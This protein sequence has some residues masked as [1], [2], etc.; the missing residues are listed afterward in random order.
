MV[1][2]GRDW[3][4]TPIPAG[5]MK[6][7]IILIGVMLL[8][9]IELHRHAN[10]HG[11]KRCRADPQ[12]EIE[13][14]FNVEINETDRLNQIDQSMNTQMPVEV[15]EENKEVRSNPEDEIENELKTDGTEL[16]QDSKITPK[17][18]HRNNK[19]VENTKQILDT[20]EE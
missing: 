16:A 11:H 18:G 2:V 12:T 20:W 15:T 3:R 10:R 1:I 7:S 5:K 9:A 8:R 19:L 4:G 6:F 17:P 13:K 14:D